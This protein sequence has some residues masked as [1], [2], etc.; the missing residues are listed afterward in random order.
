[1]LKT[2]AI[3][4]LVSGLLGSVWSYAVW[5][6]YFVMLPHAPDISAG[7]AHPANFH[8]VVLYETRQEHLKRV[9]IEYGSTGLFVLGMLLGAL[10]ERNRR[11]RNIDPVVH[12]P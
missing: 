10:Y 3:L 1:M 8:G 11:A 12:R 6:Q 2:C 9:G 7:R 5:N 4:L